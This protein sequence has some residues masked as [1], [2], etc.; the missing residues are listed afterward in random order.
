MCR[1]YWILNS[2]SFSSSEF[3]LYKSAKGDNE[4]HARRIQ[5]INSLIYPLTEKGYITSN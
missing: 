3:E 4:L 5:I 2:Q 1:L